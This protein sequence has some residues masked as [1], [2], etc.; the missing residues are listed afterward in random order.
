MSAYA[1]SASSSWFVNDQGRA[2]VR[3]PLVARSGCRPG[4]YGA[5]RERGYCV[6]RPLVLHGKPRTSLGSGGQTAF[7]SGQT[8][9][10]QP[11]LAWIFRFSGPSRYETDRGRF[12][13]AVG[14]LEL[15]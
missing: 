11:L 8:A 5:G 13:S 2:A 3:P 12:R 9:V 6:V 10:K 4:A 14:T 7:K 1:S 15:F